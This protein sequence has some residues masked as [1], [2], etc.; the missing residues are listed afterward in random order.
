MPLAGR[1]I[2]TIQSLFLLST[3]WEP[4]QDNNGC[5]RL[6][7]PTDG[8]PVVSR[9]KGAPVVGVD[10]SAAMLGKAAEIEGSPGA[11]PAEAIE[12]TLRRR[13]EVAESAMAR[14][15]RALETGWDPDGLTSQYNA[16]VAEKR[17]AVAGLDALEPTERLTAEDVRAMVDQLG[18]MRMVLDL[19]ERGDLAELYRTLRLAIS[20]DHRPRVADVSI[21]PTPRVV[22]MRVRG[23][24]AP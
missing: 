15:Q 18:G 22:S 8:L 20:Y 7:A 10:V 23:G 5:W 16:A 11:D 6:P 4:L 3:C 21:S 2:L 13:I 14:L 1:T 24:H 12:A 19:A 17:A 9:G